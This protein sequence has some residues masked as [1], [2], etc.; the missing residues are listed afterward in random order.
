MDNRRNFPRIIVLNLGI[1]LR[2]TNGDGY[3]IVNVSEGGLCLR[4]KGGE[5]VTTGTPFKGHLSWAE[6]RIEHDVDGRIV[7]SR[8]Y[9]DGDAFY[10]MVA[11]IDWLMDAVGPYL[12]EDVEPEVTGSDQGKPGGTRVGGPAA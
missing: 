9:D 4:R 6:K 12:P 2:A 7:W 1:H 8:V 10:G 3:E 5:K 11:D